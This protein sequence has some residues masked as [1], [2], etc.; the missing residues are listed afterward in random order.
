MERF[1]KLKRVVD[2]VETGLPAEG[3]NKGDNHQTVAEKNKLPCNK[4]NN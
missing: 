3:D 2:R 1:L 4:Y